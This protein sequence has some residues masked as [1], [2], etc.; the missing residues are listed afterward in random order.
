MSSELP[1]VSLCTPTF[2]RRRYIPMIIRCIE[3]QDYPKDK[4]E[5]IIVNDGVE[6]IEDILNEASKIK[7]LPKIKYYRYKNEKPI[8]LGEKRNLC[9]YY[10]SGD[11]IVN[12]DDDDY[13]P[14]DRVSHAVKTLIDNP[15]IYCAGSNILYNYFK[16]YNLIGAL[17]PKSSNHAYSGTLAFKK[18]LLKITQYSNDDK[19]VEETNFLL[20][21]NV[22]VLQLDPL[23]TIL[24]LSH[25]TNTSGRATIAEKHNTCI[26]EDKNLEEFIKDDYILNLFTQ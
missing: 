5:W 8:I 15:K 3:L 1:F 4:M 6:E 13:Y 16:N 14:P 22:P 25:E 7:N 19:A 17:G 12:I 24:A 26:L 20:N 21:F 9:N 18:D 10:A 11:I 2:N 23:K